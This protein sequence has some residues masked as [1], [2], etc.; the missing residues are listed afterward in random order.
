MKAESARAGRCLKI[1]VATL[2]VEGAFAGCRDFYRCLSAMTDAQLLAAL[3]ADNFELILQGSNFPPA[4]NG[5]AP[6]PRP[7][8]DS[9]PTRG[10]GRRENERTLEPGPPALRLFPDPLD[11]QQPALREGE[12]EGRKE[13][14]SRCGQPHAASQRPP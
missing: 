7:T 13:R 10:G 12:K 1:A 3:A 6:F 4:T 5:P 8:L 14:S 11:R 9:G 2:S